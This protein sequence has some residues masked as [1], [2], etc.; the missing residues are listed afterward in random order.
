MLRDGQFL[1]EP[2]VKIGAHYVPARR[3]EMTETE[4][5]TQSV[6]LGAAPKPAKKSRTDVIALA[7]AAYIVASLLAHFYG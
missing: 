5:F 7:I 3:H 4:L 1:A 6:L 2:P